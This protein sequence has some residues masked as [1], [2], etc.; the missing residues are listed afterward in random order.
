MGPDRRRRVARGRGSPAYRGSCCG[1][2][3]AVRR[4]AR[5]RRSRTAA[6]AV[7]RCPSDRAADWP[8][9]HHDVRRPPHAPRT[10]RAATD[11][12]AP[13]RTTPVADHDRRAGSRP[14]RRPPGPS[15]TR[16]CRRP[17]PTRAAQPHVDARSAATAPGRTA[18]ALPHRAVPAPSPP[19]TPTAAGPTPARPSPCLR[20]RRGRSA[21]TALQT[22]PPRRNYRPPSPVRVPAAGEDWF[23]SRQDWVWLIRG[24]RHREARV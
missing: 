24:R 14:T 22:R 1:E 10:T 21:G 16:P 5:P 2:S 9:S 20:C 13:R 17:Q 11:Q 3:S 23:C 8:A 6:G 15:R 12:P 4:P 7:A 18:A 19:R